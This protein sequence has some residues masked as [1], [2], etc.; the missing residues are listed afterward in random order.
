[1]PA[2][3]TVEQAAAVA[4]IRYADAPTGLIS[5]G[6]AA[7]LAEAVQAALDD[8]AI[9]ALILT[10]RDDV[11][12]RH[13]DVAQIARA[14]EALDAGAIQ[15][16]SF[17]GA[18]FD[19]LGRMIEGADKPVIA[20]INGACM[21]GGFEIALA[22]HM[23]IAQASVAAIG[24]PEIRLDLFPGAGGPERL[25]RLVG[26]HRARLFMLEG[27]VVTA[28]AALAQGL[29]DAVAPDAL[30]AALDAAARWTGRSAS[31]VAAVLRLTRPPAGHAE[32]SVLAFGELLRD[33]AAL[34]PRLAR[35][36]AD[37]E[38]LDRLP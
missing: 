26:P 34:R 5:N 10:G 22:C 23:R 9:R 30:N 7:R 27:A 1:M 29:V 36:I 25:A 32:G 20:A 11:F 2:S 37:G 19:R 15:P 6:G 38:A 24:L 16:A 12:I 3:V 35:F 14:A 31:A 17:V 8:P 21:G 13:A 33:Q 18:P 4:V 28:E